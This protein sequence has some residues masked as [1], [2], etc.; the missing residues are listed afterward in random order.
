MFGLL[1]K[2]V[3][4]RK[5]RE[6]V[7]GF[8]QKYRETGATTAEFAAWTKSHGGAPAERLLGDWLTS[9]RWLERL[10]SGETLDAMAKGYRSAG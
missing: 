10:K 2:S 5:F 1:E 6:I 3:G 8:Y 4:A 7:G 9:T